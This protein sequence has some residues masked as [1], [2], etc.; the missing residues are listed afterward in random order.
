VSGIDRLSLA[1]CQPAERKRKNKI[2]HADKKTEVRGGERAYV[3]GWVDPNRRGGC[4][5][6]SAAPVLAS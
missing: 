2:S 4:V 5:E 6:T 3:V 1:R